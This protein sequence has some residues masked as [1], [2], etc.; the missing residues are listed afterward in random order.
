MGTPSSIILAFNF[1]P[2][3]TFDFECNFLLFNP[4]AMLLLSLLLPLFFFRELDEVAVDEDVDAED[5]AADEAADE[6]PEEADEAAEEE[7]EDVFAFLPPLLPLPPLLL[8][9]PD[10]FGLFT[11]LGYIFSYFVFSC[12]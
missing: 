5:E 6:A 4:G 12:R 2:T 11:V 7:E 8:F 10:D 1:V 9:C 3:P